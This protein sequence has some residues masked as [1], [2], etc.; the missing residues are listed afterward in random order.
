MYIGAIAPTLKIQ[1]RE[2]TMKRYVKELAADIL[3][4]NKACLHA[5]Q[6]DIDCRNEAEEEIKNTLFFCEKGFITDFEAVIKLI[7]IREKVMDR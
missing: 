4:M 5:T 1:R 3:H 2:N 7:S 6:A